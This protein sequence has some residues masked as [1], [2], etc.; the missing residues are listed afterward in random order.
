[1]HDDDGTP[2]AHWK[3][4]E[5]CAPATVHDDDG[6]PSAHWTA[7]EK[8]APATVHDGDELTEIAAAAIVTGEAGALG[9][10]WLES[11]PDV[12]I[13]GTSEELDRLNALTKELLKAAD[14]CADGTD[15]KVKTVGEPKA[16][17][18][19]NAKKKRL[20]Q[21]RLMKSSPPRHHVRRA[22]AGVWLRL[23]GFDG[24]GGCGRHGGS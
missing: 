23:A 18:R 14:G 21:Q 19:S 3:A 9:S 7:E 20:L 2:S 24:L 12:P 13:A 22:A 8:C 6:T 5:K 11:T 1:V 4:E 17:P 16:A 10:A 15:R